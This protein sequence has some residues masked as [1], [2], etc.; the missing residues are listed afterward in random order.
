MAFEKIEKVKTEVEYVGRDCPNCQSPLIYRYSHKTR[1]KFI[2]C[3]KFPECKYLEPLEKPKLL[4]ENCPK[5]GKQ[6]AQ[7]TSRWSR[8]GQNAF[9]G[10]TGYPDCNFMRSMDGQEIVPKPRTSKARGKKKTARAKTKKASDP[11]SE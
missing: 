6:L 3:P 4:D 8:G 9:I 2:G 1:N 7:R 10:C 5:C 11:E